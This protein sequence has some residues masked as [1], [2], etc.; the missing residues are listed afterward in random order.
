MANKCVVKVLL[1]RVELDIFR[2]TRAESSKEAAPRSLGASATHDA[3]EPSKA[4]ESVRLLFLPS[5]RR[6]GDVYDTVPV[7]PPPR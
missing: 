7:R 5:K 2:K 3:P 4:T 6:H 1:W